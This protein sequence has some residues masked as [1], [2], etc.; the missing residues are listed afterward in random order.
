[1]RIEN[2]PVG[3][4]KASPEWMGPQLQESKCDVSLMSP[5][6]EPRA[7][8]A[9]PCRP[10]APGLRATTI[11]IRESDICRL[12]HNFA[13]ADGSRYVFIIFN[14]YK[15]RSLWRSWER[16]AW[17]L[18]RKV[19]DS[20]GSQLG[21]IIICIV[22]RIYPRL[23]TCILVAMVCHPVIRAPTI[24]NVPTWFGWV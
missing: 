18:E 8:A 14:G 3:Q 12:W 17:M 13:V 19:L 20:N 2:S 6:L 10:A 7:P 11:L 24:V 5:R 22:A 23:V 15:R 16:R 21:T 4:S 9:P 1:M